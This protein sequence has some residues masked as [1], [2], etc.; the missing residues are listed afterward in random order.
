MLIIH[1]LDKVCATVLKVPSVKIDYDSVGGYYSL[2]L[3]K[4][5][6]VNFEF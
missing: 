4:C 5:N 2:I 3:S 1:H 6:I